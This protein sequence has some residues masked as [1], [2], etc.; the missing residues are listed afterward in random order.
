MALGVPRKANPSPERVSLPE[1]TPQPR[2]C[3]LC[4]QALTR[5]K[6]TMDIRGETLSFRPMSFH[7]PDS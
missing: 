4:E 3:A 7:P 2:E 5:G 6:R 1:E